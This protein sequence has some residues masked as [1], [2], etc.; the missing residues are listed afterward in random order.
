MPKLGFEHD[1]VWLVR[2]DCDARL[3]GPCL[4]R[5]RSWWHVSLVRTRVQEHSLC[6]VKGRVHQGSDRLVV[7]YDDLRL[8]DHVGTRQDIEG[9]VDL[10]VS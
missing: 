3:G 6:W 9:L 4:R 7:V 1:F 5:R 8:V 2:Q 10:D